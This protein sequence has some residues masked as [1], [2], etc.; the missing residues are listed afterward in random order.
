[1]AFKVLRDKSI[2]ILAIAILLSSCQL[3][4]TG[5]KKSLLNEDLSVE[6]KEQSIEKKV[7]SSDSNEEILAESEE[8]KS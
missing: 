5:E 7:S 2:F 8:E 1:M 4:T 6:D 3:T